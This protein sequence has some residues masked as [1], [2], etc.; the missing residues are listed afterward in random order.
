MKG[1]VYFCCLFVSLF[2]L[3]LHFSTEAG[4]DDLLLKIG[5][6]PIKEKGKAPDFCLKNLNGKN[7]EFKNFRGKVIFLNFWATWCGP[8]REEIP[9]FSKIYA[10]YKNK[11]VEFLGISLDDG[12]L[13]EVRDLVREF[14]RKYRVEYTMAVGNPDVARDFG[15][16]ASL[17]TTFVIDQN[18]AIVK[19]YTGYSPA[20]TRDIEQIIK[21]LIG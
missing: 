13:S 5:I 15:D 9:E 3:G 7:V 6:R 18:G 19:K 12:E 16:V 4:E 14:S 21:S 1:K 20:V 17:P 11:G 2:L 10:S 8:C